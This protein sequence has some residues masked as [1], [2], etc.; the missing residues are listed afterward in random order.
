MK[1]LRSLFIGVVGLLFV[2]QLALVAPVAAQSPKQ[3]ER[4]RLN[5]VMDANA[6]IEEF[7]QE[8]LNYFTEMEDTVRL[9]NEVRVV[10]EKLNKNGLKPLGVIAEAKNSITNAKPDDLRLLRDVYAKFPGWR[11]APQN[12]NALLK[13]DFRQHLEARRAAN[14]AG[15]GV[16]P[17][18]VT[19]DNCADGISADVSN[20]DIAAAQS[21]S[22]AAHAIADAV[23][24]VLNIPAVAAYVIT[25]AIVISLETLKAIKDDCTALDATSVQGIIDGA[26]TEI[27][28]N[29]NF[30][31]TTIVN[32]DD[33]NKDTI[34]SNLTSST[35]SINNNVTASK[36]EIIANDNSN[37]TMLTTAI[38]NAKNDIIANDNSNKTMLTTAINDAQ[39]SLTTTGSSNTTAIT[40]AITNATNT[41]VNNDNSNKTM[42][43]N[44]DNANALTLNTNL[45]NAKNTI[46]A[47][48]NTNTANIVN[49]DNTNTTTLINSGNANTTALTDL[50]LRS[51][52]E[53]DLATE[54]NG[55]KVGWYMTPTANGGKLDLVKQIVTLTLANIQAA[56]GS[57]GNAQSFL[58]RANADKAAGNFKSAYDN[59]RK[60][61]KAAV[62]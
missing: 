30:N 53:A 47:N 24:P 40:T 17:N 21:A 61:Y 2:M 58:D 13:P 9:F 45:T 34:L 5:R 25:D 44:N 8:M 29:D 59:Y 12:I 27:I 26:K 32:N 16:I 41:I 42:I 51:Q 6:N 14:K 1:N 49:N 55:V 56:G 46:I 18:A 43:V 48:D 28:N 11:N 3:I 22:L 19:P 23:P 37:K 52:I 33:T 35:T 50:L 31:K 62:N 10:R 20:T 38:A 60:A 15:G 4:E 57:I 39:T 7:R 54:S 36:S